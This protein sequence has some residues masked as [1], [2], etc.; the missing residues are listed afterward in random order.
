[1]SGSMDGSM[2][3]TTNPSEGSGMQTVRVKQGSQPGFGDV[4]VGVMIAGVKEGVPTARLAVRTPDAEDIVDLGEGEEF[5]VPGHGR[6]TVVAVHPR[7]ERAERDAV[8]LG[9]TPVT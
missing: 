5:E 1:M 3:V 2:G 9:W 7:T 6:V 8:T 4:L